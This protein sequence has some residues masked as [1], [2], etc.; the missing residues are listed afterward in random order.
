[1][2]KGVGRDKLVVWDQEIQTTINKIDIKN[3]LN[4]AGN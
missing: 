1:M 4:S 3:L 2:G